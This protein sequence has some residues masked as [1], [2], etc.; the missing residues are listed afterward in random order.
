VTDDLPVCQRLLRHHSL[1]PR[2][3]TCAR[4]LSCAPG[5]QPGVWPR[6]GVVRSPAGALAS[7]A[8][9]VTESHGAQPPRCGIVAVS[10]GRP[11]GLA[12]ESR[13]A[14]GRPGREVRN[15][16]G[17]H[18]LMRHWGGSPGP[19]AWRSPGRVSEGRPADWCLLVAGEGGPAGRCLLV[20]G[21]AGSPCLAGRQVRGRNAQLCECCTALWRVRQ[22]WR[23]VAGV[24]KS[25][26]PESGSG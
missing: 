20:N 6:P 26:S 13:S 5:G 12:R 10:P 9:P 14:V 21:I 19:R 18:T 4:F 16:A 3:V 2:Q 15:C 25:R 23:T 7:R 24:T 22:H 8:S 1:V 17:Q 11:G